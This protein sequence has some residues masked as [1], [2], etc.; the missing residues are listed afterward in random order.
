MNNYTYLIPFID[1]PYL[2]E[3]SIL[4]NHELVK[5]VDDNIKREALKE[6]FNANNDRINNDFFLIVDV[7][8]EKLEQEIKNILN[9]PYVKEQL[10]VKKLEKERIKVIEDRV[11]TVLNTE[12]IPKQII[13][14]KI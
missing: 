2:G 8:K 5:D 6:Y 14:K 1:S 13:P 10:P 7:K 3:A 12:Y 11:Q 4:Y 9:K